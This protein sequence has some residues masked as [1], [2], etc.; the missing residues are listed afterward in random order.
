MND[1]TDNMLRNQKKKILIKLLLLEETDGKVTILSK[2]FNKKKTHDLF[3]AK[4]IVRFYSILIEKHL[5]QDLTEIQR[6]V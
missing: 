3:L 6:I 2:M 5:L 4:K 1:F